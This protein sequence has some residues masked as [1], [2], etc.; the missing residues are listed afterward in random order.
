MDERQQLQPRQPRQP[1]QDYIA[2]MLRPGEDGMPSF[3]R[4]LIIIGFYITAVLTT[5]FVLWMMFCFVV[6]RPLYYQIWSGLVDTVNTIK[7]FALALAGIGTVYVGGRAITGILARLPQAEFYDVPATGGYLRD[8]WGR[9]TPLPALST[10]N[11]KTLAK[12]RADAAKLSKQEREFELSLTVME[13]ISIG[14]IKHFSELSADPD[15]DEKLMLPVGID[16]EVF[17]KR[18]TNNIIR[19][20]FPAASAVIGKGRSGKTRRVIGMVCFAIAMGMEVTVCDPHAGKRDG[21]SRL[22]A[23][24]APWLRIARGE[25]ETAQAAREY[26]AEMER[27][28]SGDSREYNLQKNL[29]KPRLIIFDEWSR[30]MTVRDI[31]SDE[32]R[33]TIKDCA[34]RAS[35]EFAGVDGFCVVIGQRWSDADAGGTDTRRSLMVD[36]IHNISAEYA[37]FFLRESKLQKR[38]ETLKQRECL[39]KDYSG[40]VLE[41]LTLNTPDNTVSEM[42]NWLREKEVPALPVVKP[43]LP[44]PVVYQPPPTETMPD[45]PRRVTQP[46]ETPTSTTTTSTTEELSSKNSLNEAEVEA[47]VEVEQGLIDLIDKIAAGEMSAHEVL[48]M[49]GKTGGRKYTARK[50]AIEQIQQISSKEDE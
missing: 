23:P 39:Y 17:R 28:L 44:A 21:I 47:E 26:V 16:A 36:Y 50:Q 11:A 5:A 38:A 49:T 9:V 2:P 29:S 30:L 43:A 1:R 18:K 46:L 10:S 25:Q 32:D 31:I 12:K 45:I 41:V 35:A 37:A 48:K 24:L 3:Y 15:V 4:F 8:V 33:E 13:M 34:R 40:D 14:E 6:N 22:L 42:V 19:D 20:P 27:R 7:L